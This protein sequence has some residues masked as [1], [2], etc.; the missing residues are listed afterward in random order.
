MKF[1]PDD[2]R[3]AVALR[4]KAARWLAGGRAADGRHSGKAIALSTRQLADLPL[5]RENGITRNRLEDFE[6]MTTDAKPMELE[7]IEQAL[8]LPAGWLQHA[9]TTADE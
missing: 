9:P 4:L 6:Q 7:K 5:L 2:A 8:G 3:L 1:N